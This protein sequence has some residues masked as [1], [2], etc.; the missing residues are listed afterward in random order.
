MRLTPTRP[1]KK[2]QTRD[3]VTYNG[4]IS[5]CAKA[6][7][8]ILALKLLQVMEEEYIRPNVISYSSAT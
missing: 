3:V 5:A 1:R 8:K 4:A 6:G 7:R 2:P